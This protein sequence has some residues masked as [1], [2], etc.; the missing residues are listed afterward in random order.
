MNE[1][2]CVCQA[3]AQSIHA[4]RQTLIWSAIGYRLSGY[5]EIGR[6]VVNQGGYLGSHLHLLVSL[7]IQLEGGDWVKGVEGRFHYF[8]QLPAVSINLLE[9]IKIWYNIR[10]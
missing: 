10:L 6:F 4:S 8:I 3:G 7:F 2:V 9:Y 1:R 5:T